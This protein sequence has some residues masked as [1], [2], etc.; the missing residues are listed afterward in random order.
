MSLTMQFPRLDVPRE[1]PTLA[2]S[3][4][5]WTVDTLARLA[6][7]LKIDADAVDAGLWWIARDRRAVL[8]VYQ[9]TQSFRMSRVDHD[10]EARGSDHLPI[11]AD[12]ARRVADAWI[13]EFG[14]ADSQSMV[15]SITE[16]ESLVS[17]R[18]NGKPNAKIVARDVNYRFEV[19]GIPLFGPGA[20]AKVSVH[21]SGDV[22]SAYC[23]WR[24]TTTGEAVPTVPAEVLFERFASSALFA[25][26]TERTARVEVAAAR[27]GYLCLP[28]TEPMSVLVPAVEIRGTI[29]TE[30]NPRYEFV[31]YVAATDMDG[32][33]AKRA[34]L[35]N[36][37]PSLLIA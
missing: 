6:S 25:D 31:R 21:A 12:E 16:H 19:G 27:F 15:H 13:T 3:N 18:R 23:F 7:R 8:E 34:R 2:A 14:P 9:A 22:S 17:S 11:G 36:A 24:E 37:R 5:R 20:K 28:P 30:A 29:A 10:G 32:A 4:E 1:V 33:E 26:L 35:V